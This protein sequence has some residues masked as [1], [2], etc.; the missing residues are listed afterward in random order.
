M[1]P[2]TRDDASVTG[3][4]L[5]WLVSEACWSSPFVYRD[6]SPPFWDAQPSSTVLLTQVSGSLGP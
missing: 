5:P 4:A 2:V 6:P 1:L 3:L